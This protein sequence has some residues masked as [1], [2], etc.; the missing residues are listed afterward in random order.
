VKAS[1]FMCWAAAVRKT[2]AAAGCRWLLLTCMELGRLD[3]NHIENHLVSIRLFLVAQPGYS[4]APDVARF[5]GTC[6]NAGT[7]HQ[8]AGSKQTFQT[9]SNI[10]LQRTHKAEQTVLPVLLC[11]LAFSSHLLRPNQESS[12]L[13]RT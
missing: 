10:L 11:F 7:P 2:N 4:A 12:P 13:I 3:Q 8:P 1:L 9:E 6:Q 5:L